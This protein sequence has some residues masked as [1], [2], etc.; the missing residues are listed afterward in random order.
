MGEY[1]EPISWKGQFFGQYVSGKGIYITAKERADE[2]LRLKGRVVKWYYEGIKQLV[3]IKE[4]E[5]SYN[6]YMNVEYSITLQPHD[7][8]IEIKPEQVIQ[9]VGQSLVFT[10][11]P[12]KI[13]P[14]DDKNNPTNGVP[15]TDSTDT[16][17]RDIVYYRDPNF[18]SAAYQKLLKASLKDEKLQSQLIGK[19]LNNT[20]VIMG[21]RQEFEKDP[22]FRQTIRE[23]LRLSREL[24]ALDKTY[25]EGLTV[26]K[27]RQILAKEFPLNNLTNKNL[28]N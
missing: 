14:K 3:I 27:V 13:D 15:F 12:I 11:E 17:K 28:G 18:S 21:F 7:I 20:N 24:T 16:I 4:L 19:N 6:N 22:N 5:Y 10:E 23:E 25:K 8:Q 9:L 1:L 2:L 26:K